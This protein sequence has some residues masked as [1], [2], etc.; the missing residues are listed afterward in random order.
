MHLVLCCLFLS[1]L[2]YSAES[3]PV[4]FSSSEFIMGSLIASE[5]NDWEFRFA[6]HEFANTSYSAHVLKI[7]M[8]LMA[9]PER[10]RFEVL[11]STVGDVAGYRF[12]G[13]ANASLQARDYPADIQYA[14]QLTYGDRGPENFQ[15]ALVINFDQP[16][17]LTFD[18]PFGFRVAVRNP[19]IGTKMFQAAYMLVNLTAIDPFTFESQNIPPTYYVSANLECGNSPRP[20]FCSSTIPPL[21]RIVQGSCACDWDRWTILGF[22]LHKKGIGFQT[23]DA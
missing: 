20:Y 5:P 3:L 12:L 2:T 14:D 4:T 11:N 1:A 8:L 17:S 19:I 10:S 23:R 18:E 9:D 7:E 13:T 22:L 21:G 16:A 6:L 15:Q